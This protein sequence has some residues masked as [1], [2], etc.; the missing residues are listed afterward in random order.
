MAV[1]QQGTFADR[2]NEHLGASDGGIILMRKMLR[3]SMALIDAGK[4][5]FG[6]IRDP[7]AQHIH[8]PHKSA[9]MA[10]RHEGVSYGMGLK[11]ESAAAE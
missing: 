3:E 5:P 8:F 11:Q 4:D 9:L 7:A 1:E 2:E 10:E 6:V